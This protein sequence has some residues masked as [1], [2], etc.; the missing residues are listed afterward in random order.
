MKNGDIGRVEATFI[1]WMFVF[2]SVRKHKY[3]AHL[4]KVIHDM[5]HV[6]DEK[7]RHIIQ[8][9]WLINPTGKPDGFRGVDWVVELV[10]LYTKVSVCIG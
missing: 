3:T 2:K 7:L 10:N 4:M 9:N 5:N 8:M 1:H 6:Y